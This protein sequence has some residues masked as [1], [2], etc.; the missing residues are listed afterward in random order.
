MEKKTD[1]KKIICVEQK[2]ETWLDFVARYLSFCLVI[3]V[4]MRCFQR[5]PD[6]ANVCKK[7]FLFCKEEC[8]LY[9]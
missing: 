4:F 1:E 2:E 6:C 5:L 3:L 7:Y 8:L 9:A